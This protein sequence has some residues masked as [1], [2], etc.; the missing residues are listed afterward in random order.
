ML[1]KASALKKVNLLLGN[2]LD[3]LKEKV[4]TSNFE[5]H[6][7]IRSQSGKISQGENYNMLPYQVLDYP[8]HFEKT[9]IFALRTMFWWGHFFS[10]TLHLQGESLVKYRSSLLTNFDQLLKEELYIAVG[11][12]PWQ[13][14]YEPDNYLP[15]EPE[16]I[17]IIEQGEFVKLSKKIPVNE[18]SKLPDFASSFLQRMIRLLA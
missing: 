15:L 17:S 7:D 10:V 12:T 8:A 5:F 13:Y 18:F 3:R 4:Q 2:T 1:T 16:H 6:Q 14:H 11:N 9:D